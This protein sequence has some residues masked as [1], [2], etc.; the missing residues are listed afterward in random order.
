MCAFTALIGLVLYLFMFYH[1]YL[2]YANTTTNESMK[3]K[4]VRRT[5]KELE[6][7]NVAAAKEGDLAKSVPTVS[8][9]KIVNI[10]DRGIIEN[11]R[12]AFF[13][14]TVFQNK[15]KTPTPASTPRLRASASGGNISI[16][17][18]KPE[19]D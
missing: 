17:K 1:L 4:D 7:D 3:W 6:H 14:S 11:F 19:V 18:R 5:L 12:E 15:Y 16:N 2:V 10:Y 9:K 8:V 13:P